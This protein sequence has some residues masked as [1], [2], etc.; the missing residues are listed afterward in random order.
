MFF[1]FIIFHNHQFSEFSYSH[2]DY[3]WAL[4]DQMAQAGFYHQSSETGDDRAMC[5]TCPV[6]LVCWE[7]TD[8]PWSEHERHSPDCPFLKGEYTQNVPL[9]V[10]LATSP[11]IETGGFDLISSGDN[12]NICCIGKVS[13][14]DVTVWNVERQL[15]KCGIFNIKSEN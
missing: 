5:F 14:G 9:S 3:K 7:K 15:K 2:L 6:C 10:T 4:P 8:E 13:T 1:Y 12:G 11:S